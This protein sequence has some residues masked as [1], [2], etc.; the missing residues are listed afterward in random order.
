MLSDPQSLTI[1]AVTTS[2]PRVSADNQSAIYSSADGNVQFTVSH[3]L[4]KKRMRHLVRID[5]RI[6]AADPLTA[7]NVQQK[8]AVYMVIDEPEVG[9]TDAQLTYLVQALK[10]WAT[11]ANVA[12]V[13]GLES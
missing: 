11:D 1:H 13:L 10:A 4:S 2:V 9:F 3:Q 6:I 7:V 12:K 8:A 5:Q